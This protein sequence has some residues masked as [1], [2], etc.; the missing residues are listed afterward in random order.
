MNTRIVR[1][2]DYSYRRE[3][4]LDVDG[5]DGVIVQEFVIPSGMTRAE[6]LAAFAMADYEE[7][8]CLPANWN[9]PAAVEWPAYVGG[10][11]R[12]LYF[13]TV[14]E[15][16][17]QEVRAEPE[18]VP[19]V[20]DMGAGGTSFILKIPCR[21][22]TMLRVAFAW[23]RKLFRACH[24]EREGDY[25]H[26][27]L[28][29]RLPNDIAAKYAVVFG[30]MAEWLNAGR[31]VERTGAGFLMPKPLVKLYRRVVPKELRPR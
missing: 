8:Q 26:I 23:S 12:L 20:H 15:L 21:D 17:T 13:T 4:S 7:S 3:A 11:N 1:V 25:I 2:L 6:A 27:D 30:G 22:T 14:P 16:V 10:D 31:L 29:D 24:A 9:T 28:P 5:R 19:Y 18:A